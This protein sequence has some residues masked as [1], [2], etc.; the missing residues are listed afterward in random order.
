MSERTFVAAEAHADD[1]PLD[2]VAD[3]AI[4]TQAAIREQ[5]A[6]ELRMPADTLLMALGCRLV[7][8]EIQDGAGA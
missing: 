5:Q 3:Y 6:P 2:R 1:A 4:T 8:R 7:R